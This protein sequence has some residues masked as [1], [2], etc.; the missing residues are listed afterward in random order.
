MEDQQS[1]PEKE[2]E[3]QE[4]SQP[5]NPLRTL[6]EN[7]LKNYEKLLYDALI[8]SG[9]LEDTLQ[10]K[11]RPLKRMANWVLIVVYLVFIPRYSFLCYLYLEDE[12]TRT[13]WQY[14]LVD[15]YEQLGMFGRCLNFC[16]IVFPVAQIMDKLLLFLFERNG[17]IYFISNIFTM[18]SETQV[19]DGIHSNDSMEPDDPIEGP[20]HR[21]DPVIQEEVLSEEDKR[22]ILLRIDNYVKMSRVLYRISTNATHFY[23][24][25]CFPLFIYLKQPSIPVAVL[26]VLNMFANMYAEHNVQVHCITIWTSYLI[27]AEYF[28]F[29]IRFLRAKVKDMK[30]RFEEEI[31]S[32]VI[33]LYM[34][35]MLEFKIQDLLLKHLLRNLIFLYIAELSLMLFL[36]TIDVNPLLRIILV[37]PPLV[38]SVSIVTTGL[39]IGQVHSKTV[40]L[41]QDL[42]HSMANNSPNNVSLKSKRKLLQ[43]IKLLGNDEVDG[44]F[45]MGLR[46]GSGPATSSHEIFHL[47]L[48]T[49]TYTLMFLQ[50]TYV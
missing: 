23:D 39:F 37:I 50:M 24:Y 25:I 5:E 3:T 42:N 7:V 29:R 40:D 16:Y 44:Q 11:S 22:Q 18:F 2:P 35:L 43:A 38:I 28:M 9:S 32:Q 31:V 27:T 48:E 49:V 17:R 36:V 30:D 26:A 19:D 47:T 8:I 21:E 45:V 15:Y 13:F 14:Y 46:D 4:E 10:N 1:V 41:Y 34:K 6:S 33:S 20:S 12:D